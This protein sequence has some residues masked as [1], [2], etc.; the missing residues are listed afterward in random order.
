ME[1][2]KELNV[3]PGCDNGNHSIGTTNNTV[4]CICK[5]IITIIINY[6]NNTINPYNY[7]YRNTLITL[8]NIL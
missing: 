7:N 2:S 1:D 6:I 5:Y 8:H 3:S 4:L